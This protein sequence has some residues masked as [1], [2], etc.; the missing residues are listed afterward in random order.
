MKKLICEIF[1]HNKKNILV[2]HTSLK[3][4]HIFCNRCE[5]RLETNVLIIGERNLLNNSC[6]TK[7]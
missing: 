2:R 3:R 6:I 5:K 7:K 1:G 4:G